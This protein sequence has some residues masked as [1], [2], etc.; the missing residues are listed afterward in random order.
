LVQKNYFNQTYED[1]HH[2]KRIPD[3][4]NQLLWQPKIILDT[5]EYEIVFYSSDNNGDYE[6]C[7]EGVTTNGKPVS[8]RKI[9]SVR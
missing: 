5:N 9:I 7:L 3:F 2:Y 8:V 4:R 1:N 6:I